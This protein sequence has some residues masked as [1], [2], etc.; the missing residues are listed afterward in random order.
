MEF[1]L[2]FSHNSQIA[3][4]LRSLRVLDKNEQTARR[5]YRKDHLHVDV[6]R[7]L[8]ETERQR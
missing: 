1:E 5:I 3:A 2:N 4:L 8:M 6:Q 7:H